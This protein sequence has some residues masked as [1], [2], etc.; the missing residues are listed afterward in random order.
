LSG[1]GGPLTSTISDLLFRDLANI[2]D[3]SNLCVF[4]HLSGASISGQRVAIFTVGSYLTFS[5]IL[6]LLIE[7]LLSSSLKTG[8]KESKVSFKKDFLT[9]GSRLEMLLSCSLV[10]IGVRLVANLRLN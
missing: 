4:V 8:G 5:Y 2:S 9:L 7:D 1:I 10:T 3:E 6:T